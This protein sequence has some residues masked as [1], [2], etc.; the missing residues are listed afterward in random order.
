MQEGV[1]WLRPML[2]TQ[3]DEDNRLEQLAQRKEELAAK[4]AEG[5]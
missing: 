5:T 1:E 3:D 2:W 4:A